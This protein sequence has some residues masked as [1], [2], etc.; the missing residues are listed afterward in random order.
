M[1]F[2]DFNLNVEG[3]NP[4][5]WMLV[6]TPVDTRW[7]RDREEKKKKCWCIKQKKKWKKKYCT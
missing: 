3:E 4:L 2:Y 5:S 7:E 6:I 1:E